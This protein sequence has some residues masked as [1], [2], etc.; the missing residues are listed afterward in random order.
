MAKK[1]II[2]PKNSEFIKFKNYE[3]NKVNIYNLCRFW[4][5]LSDRGWLKQNPE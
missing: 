2:M 4:E 5:Y 3:K 1:K